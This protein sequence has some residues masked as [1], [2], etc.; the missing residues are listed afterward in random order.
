MGVY[1][2]SRSNLFRSQRVP[3]LIAKP[4]FIIVQIA[5]SRLVVAF[6]S[7]RFQ[8]QLVITR[9]QSNG[10]QNGDELDMDDIPGRKF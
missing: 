7:L 3:F 4:C 10:L 8:V 5:K 2:G 9:T 6:V 1:R